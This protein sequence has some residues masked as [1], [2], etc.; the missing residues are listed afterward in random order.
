MVPSGNRWIHLSS[1]HKLLC[2]KPHQISVTAD[3][4]LSYLA[5]PTL[6]RTTFWGKILKHCIWFLRRWTEWVWTA[7]NLNFKLLWITSA[8]HSI[9]AISI[10]K[11]NQSICA[12]AASTLY[13]HICRFAWNY[14]RNCSIRAGAQSGHSHKNSTKTV[15][16]SQGRP[17][18]ECAKLAFV[19]SGLS[20]SWSHLCNSSQLGCMCVQLWSWYSQTG[21]LYNCSCTTVHSWPVVQAGAAR[22]AWWNWAV[23]PWQPPRP[24]QV[25]VKLSSW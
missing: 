24:H 6:C 16:L 13:S 8:T 21:G 10:Y 3:S 22:T 19:Y 20:G 1:S 7:N 4:G 2:W 23:R 18:K 25:S 14:R 11:R 17:G 15:H 12:L 5:L 9:L